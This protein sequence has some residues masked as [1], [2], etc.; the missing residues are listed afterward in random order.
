[1]L[2]KLALCAFA[3]ALI[4]SSASASTPSLTQVAAS[5][6]P[7]FGGDWGN[8]RYSALK[9]IDANNVAKLGGAWMLPLQAESSTVTPLVEDGVMYVIAG[10]HVYSLDARDGAKRWTYTS[11]VS[12]GPRG[13]AL[14]EELVFV[15]T[16][17]GSIHALQKSSGKLV[18]ETFIGDEPKMLGQM[19]SGAPGYANGVVVAGL[20]N[21]DFGLRGRV[22]ALDAKTGKLLWRFDTIPNPGDFGSE[23]WP[24]DND[25]WK[26]GGAGVWMAPAFD[27]KLNLVY[28]GVGNAV[29]QWGGEVRAGDNLF[30]GAVIALDLK[31]GKRRWHYQLVRHDIWDHDLGTPMVLYDAKVNGKIRPALAA[32]RTDGYLFLLDRKTG[33]PIHKVEERPV[34]QHAFSHTAPTQPFPV[35]ADAV[36]PR[37]VEEDTVPPGFIR[38]CYFDVIDFR[39]NLMHLVLTTRGAPM[40]YSADT[41]YFYVTGSIAPFWVR[42]TDDPWFFYYTGVVP[43]MKQ[44]GLLTAIDSRT[45]KIVWEH[46]LPYKIGN[47]SGVLTTAGNLAFHGHPDGRFLAYDARSGKQLWEYQLGSGADGPAVSYDINGE[48]HLAIAARGAIWAFKLGGKVA[49]LPAA[50]SAPTVTGFVG[51]IE[52]SNEVQLGSTYSDGGLAGKRVEPDEFGLKP[53]RARIEAGTSLKFV[54]KTE[55]V[56]T[57]RALDKSWKAGPVQPGGEAQ[58]ELSTP[59]TFT[60]ICEEHPWTYG[61]VTVE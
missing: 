14:G 31:T 23:T 18:W 1:M 57:L 37:C 26:K 52:D 44:Y 2:Q 9:S 28:Y 40:S 21:G 6:W 43:G 22:V 30:T 4:F 58:V 39:P 3:I 5:E 34:P 41:G 16:R 51:I 13:V 27:P 59:G 19:I 12:L 33:E 29:P 24:K 11:K 20:A 38:Q 35:D 32:M 60:Y 53:Q 50:P 56:H 46:K 54:N 7:A 49:Q 10:V 48:Q 42:R 36:G 15:G 8:T 25:S 55:S 45:N 47:G 17:D 61:E